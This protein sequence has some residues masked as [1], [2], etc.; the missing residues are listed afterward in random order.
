VQLS[1]VKL[2]LKHSNWGKEAQ[3]SAACDMAL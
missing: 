3:T 1:L 2:M